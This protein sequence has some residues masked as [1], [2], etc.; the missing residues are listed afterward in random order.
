M[1]TALPYF[2]AKTVVDLPIQALTMFLFTAIMYF[3]AGL[4]EGGFFL[5]WLILLVTALTAQSAGLLLGASVSDD[6]LLM[7]LAPLLFFPVFLFSGPLSTNI[8][9]GM[10]WIEYIVFFKYSFILLA[11]NEFDGLSF[12]LALPPSA[13]SFDGKDALTRG[14]PE[15]VNASAL[16]PAG[17]MMAGTDFLNVIGIND[18]S[19]PVA[20]LI[21]LLLMLV[22]R[23]SA[24]IVLTLRLRRK[25]A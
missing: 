17:A 16:V 13:P 11:N 24:F 12:A 2:F 9:I 3:M 14:I 22:L 20:W 8:P 19:V 4:R 6:R 7:V 15:S 1:Y 18:V 5:F 10:A 23:G 21:L 25:M